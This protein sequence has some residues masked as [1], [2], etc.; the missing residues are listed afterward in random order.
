MSDKFQSTMILWWFYVSSWDAI[1]LTHIL[2]SIE[3]TGAPSCRWIFIQDVPTVITTGALCCPTKTMAY[4]AKYPSELC[5]CW[6]IPQLMSYV[7]CQHSG[8]NVS[9]RQKAIPC[10]QWVQTWDGCPKWHPADKKKLMN[11]LTFCKFPL[12]IVEP[13]AFS[14]IMTSYMYMYRD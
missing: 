8:R 11:A 7:Q 14:F 2:K 9:I 13:L 4:P 5:L 3:K 6:T 10:S 1:N 12:R